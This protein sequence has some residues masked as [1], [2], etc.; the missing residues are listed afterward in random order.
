MDV[1]STLLIV[2]LDTPG[3]A[4][5]RREKRNYDLIVQRI[6]A[7]S[8]LYTVVL[9]TL[10]EPH[11]SLPSEL[12]RWMTPTA[13]YSRER[14]RK[15]LTGLMNLNGARLVDSLRGASHIDIV[16]TRLEDCVAKVA[17]ECAETYDEARVCVL[18]SCCLPLDHMDPRT[19]K[20]VGGA[21]IYNPEEPRYSESFVRLLYR[22][23]RLHF[24]Q[25]VDRISL[26]RALESQIEDWFLGEIVWVLNRFETAGQIVCYRRRRGDPADVIVTLRH[27]ALACELKA[28]YLGLQGGHEQTLTRYRG[29]CRKAITRLTTHDGPSILLIFCYGP[30]TPKQW[31]EFVAY[32]NERTGTSVRA[33][34]RPVGI[35]TNYFL[36]LL[37]VSNATASS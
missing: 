11:H 24:D 1:T 13:I 4:Y 20:D 14:D 9:F 28:L 19:T 35:K 8:D 26:F 30:P 36:G 25:L 18:R 32:L 3:P 22:L 12:Q 21:R 34:S 5:D 15:V 7:L 33:L 2:D 16:G 27:Q 29:D 23:V 37:E 10:E 17:C 6:S 31:E